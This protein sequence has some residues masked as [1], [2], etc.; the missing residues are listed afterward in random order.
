MQQEPEP[1]IGQEAPLPQAAEIEHNEPMLQEAETEQ[2]EPM[3]QEP[4]PGIKQEAPMLQEPEPE[5]AHISQ[6]PE[7]EE[8]V[9]LMGAGSK[10]FELETLCPTRRLN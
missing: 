7:N 8:T 5:E 10:V 6:K 3:L 9:P 4:E 1:E 2:E